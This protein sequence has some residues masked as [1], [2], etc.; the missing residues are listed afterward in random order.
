M[1]I[2]SGLFREGLGIPLPGVD[3]HVLDIR[4]VTPAHL[5][6]AFAVVNVAALATDAL[7]E[8][9][10]DIAISINLDGALSLARAARDAGV[11]RFVQVSTVGSYDAGPEGMVDEDSP[12]APS[13]IYRR[14]KVEAEI[15]LLDM[16][17]DRFQVYSA[18]L[19][20]LFGDSA[21]RRLDLVLN[22]FVTRAM[23]GESLVID[24]SGEQ[25]RPLGHVR[26]AA[27]GLVRMAMMDADGIPACVVHLVREQ[28]ALRIRDLAL[29]VSAE[30]PG[31]TVGFGPPPP[32]VLPGYRACSRFDPEWLGDMPEPV[33]PRAGVHEMVRDFQA[34]P[35]TGVELRTGDR[36]RWFDEQ[37][38]LGSIG[39]DGRRSPD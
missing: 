11:S 20:T 35:L 26:D 25:W 27:I 10:P 8:R 14:S 12:A 39:S 17:T 6:G 24:G 29:L 33:D 36:A 31:T 32:V 13:S 22:R 28:L 34:R 7:G 19:P 15:A 38:R 21:N 30:I 1:G 18:R 23:A 16:G 2:D 4:D 3:E 5:D 9:H 37:S